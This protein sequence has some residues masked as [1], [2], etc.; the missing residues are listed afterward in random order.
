MIKLCS[1]ADCGIPMF[2][3]TGYCNPHWRRYKRTGPEFNR[4]KI[5]IKPIR[6]DNERFDAATMPLPESGCLIWMNRCDRDGYGLFTVTSGSIRAHRFAWM[7]VYGE[8][9]EGMFICHKC[10]V[11][12]CVNIDHLYL[13]TATDNNR[14]TVRR[15]RYVAQCGEKAHSSKLTTAQVIEIRKRV[16]AGEVHH[17]IAKDYGV[18]Q[19]CISRI[20]NRTRWKHVP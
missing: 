19:N 3:V 6:G 12:G 11:P 15:G 1:I 2:G 14:D 5:R 10:D 17:R 20:G 18:A 16:D 7:R 13:G 9:P 4:G 8:I